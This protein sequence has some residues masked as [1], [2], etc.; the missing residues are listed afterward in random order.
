MKVWIARDY[1]GLIA[2]E[3]KPV[4]NY[5]INPFDEEDFIWRGAKINSRYEELDEN[6]FPEITIINSPVEMEF[7]IDFNN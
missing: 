4:K 1:E 2:F 6:M 7:E 3:E 5:G